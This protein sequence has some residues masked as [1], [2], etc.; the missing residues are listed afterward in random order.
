MTKKLLF[1]MCVLIGTACSNPHTTENIT[2]DVTVE[3]ISNGKIYLCEIQNIHYGSAKVID[4]LTVEN[5]HTSYANDSLRTGLYA[6]ASQ[7]NH[8]Y[9][10]PMTGRSFFLQHGKNRF[11]YTATDGKQNTVAIEPLAL[12]TQYEAFQNRLKEINSVTDSIDAL[13]DTAR[14][15]G[16]REEMA[17]LKE[18]S[19]PFYEEATQRKK[20]Y[21]ASLLE[22]EKRSTFGLYLFY[23][24]RFQNRMLNSMQEIDSIHALVASYE[25][26]AQQSEFGKRIEETLKRFEAC[27]IGHE[28]PEIKGIT[29]NDKPIKLSDFRGKLVLVDFWSS[30]C[31]WCR[32]E[33]VYLKPA[34]E[35]FKDQGFTILGVSSDY[36]KEEWLKAIEEDQTHWDH[37]LIPR[38]EILKVDQDYCI[39]GIPHII[40]VSP[41]G[42][43]LEKEL[44]GEAI[45]QAITK[46]LNKSKQ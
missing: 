43:I 1:G 14:E 12:Q 30:S 34:Y 6:F 4:T 44:R 33:N 42:I 16:D 17:R 24:Y 45:E 21:I 2:L 8:D 28:A 36:K 11:C 32:K 23:A 7:I 29:Q 18:A 26:E 5:G 20:K 39:V 46:H 15:K 22:Q 31:G 25:E 35:K 41:E 40:L 27:A 3:G 37:L 38:E 10:I 9:G 13:F 19:V